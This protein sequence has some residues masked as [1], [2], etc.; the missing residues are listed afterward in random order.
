M[1]G[2]AVGGFPHKLKDQQGNVLPYQRGVAF[3]AKLGAIRVS[4]LQ[5]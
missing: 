5:L 4:L 2:I 3:G 1:S